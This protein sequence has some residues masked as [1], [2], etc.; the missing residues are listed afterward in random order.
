MG[1]QQRVDAV[2]TTSR[3]VGA[4]ANGVKLIGEMGNGIQ[5]K[6][7]LDLNGVKVT[8]GNTTGI[9]FGG[10]KIYDFPAGILHVKCVTVE[11]IAFGLSDPL[12]VTPIDSA[13]G[14][15]FSMGTTPPSDGTLTGADVNLLPSTS[16]DPLSDGVANANLASP[17]NIGTD[18]G[19]ALDAY[20][21]ILIDDADVGNAAS[22]VLTVT[23]K[24][25]I[26]WENANYVEEI[27]TL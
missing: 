14:G 22:D 12:N 27:E 4:V 7:V 13:D 8:V 11:N 10:T 26:L 9:S 21:N 23:G 24:V 1:A 2:R 18:K 20:F 19:V 6:T 17:T 3:G 15:D 25:T 16:I 5:H